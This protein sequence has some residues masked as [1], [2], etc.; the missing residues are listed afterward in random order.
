MGSGQFTTSVKAIPSQRNLFPK[1]ALMPFLHPKDHC[2]E[3][4][5][6]MHNAP[7]S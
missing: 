1:N 3:R 5:T 6:R 2:A 4:R 7:A